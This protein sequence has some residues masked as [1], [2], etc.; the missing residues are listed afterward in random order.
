VRHVYFLLAVLVILLGLTHTIATFFLFAEMNGRALWFA[1]A[2]LL[3]IVTGMLNLL[4]RAYGRAAPGLR[5]ACVATNAAMFVF[6]I[7]AGHAG[8]A[9]DLQL[10]FVVG[11]MGAA[12][13]VSTLPAATAPNA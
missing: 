3:L 12:A 4:N 13:L 9:S 7:L 10:V 11:L 2:G 1:S 6:A 8:A 5:W